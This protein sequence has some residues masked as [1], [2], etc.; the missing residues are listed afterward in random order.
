M[1]TLNEIADDLE[2]FRFDEMDKKVEDGR[3]SSTDDFV[4]AEV[5]LMDLSTVK[6]YA[7]WKRHRQ[8][9]KNIHKH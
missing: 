9:Y 8:I 5:E 6:F 2:Q 7:R 1:E 4:M 3:Y